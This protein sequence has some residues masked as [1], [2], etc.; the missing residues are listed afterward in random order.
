MGINKNVVITGGTGQLGVAAT[1]Q[2]LASGYEVYIPVFNDSE[3]ESFEYASHERVHLSAGVN[4]TDETQ[5]VKYYSSLPALWASV[6][7]AGGFAMAPLAETSKDDFLRQMNLNALSAF[8]CCREAAAKMNAAGGRIVNVAA[9]PA[10]EPRSGA[11]MVAYTAAKAAVAAMTQALGEELAPRGI[12]VNAIAPSILDTPPNRKAMPDA[13]F[14]L[15]P[16]VDEVA[17][18][19][20]YLASDE[21]KVTRSSVVSVYGKS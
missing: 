21:N 17:A 3:I 6:H 9:R 14:A 2:F 8:L 12:L 10:L 16:K 19:I 5:V 20:A 13:D 7:I 4:L 11:G 15:W 1:A 18:T